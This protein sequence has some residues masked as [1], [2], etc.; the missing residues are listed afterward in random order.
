MGLK[1]QFHL[2]EAHEETKASNVQ[3]TFLLKDARRLHSRSQKESHWVAICYATAAN[4][5]KAGVLNTDLQLPN[6][7]MPK[8]LYS[9]ACMYRSP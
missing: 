3:E 4:F 7:Q 9:I 8:C 5:D 6:Q 2:Q 1:V